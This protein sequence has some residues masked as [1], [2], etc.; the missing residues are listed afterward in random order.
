MF[1]NVYLSKIVKKDE[2]LDKIRNLIFTLYDYFLIHDEE[3]PEENREMIHEYG[4]EEV[5]KDYI[6]GMTE[7]YALN[8]FKDLFV[9]R[10]WR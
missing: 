3:L 6:A 5:V 1:Q 2:E 4:I 9:P 8:T 10:G 7:R